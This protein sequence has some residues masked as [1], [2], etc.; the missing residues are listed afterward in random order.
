MEHPVSV[1]IAKKLLDGQNILVMTTPVRY[2]A[3]VRQVSP[4]PY[5]PKA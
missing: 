3:Y 2:R 1:D 5:S 4:P